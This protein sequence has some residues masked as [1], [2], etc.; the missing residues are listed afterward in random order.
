MVN[1]FNVIDVTLEEVKKSAIEDRKQLAEYEVTPSDEYK[2]DKPRR[3]SPKNCFMKAFRY[4]ADKSHL[5]GVR[6]VHGLYKPA[7]FD[8]HSCHAWVELPND[9]VFDGVMQRFYEKEGY[10]TYYQIIKQKEYDCKIMHKIGLEQGGHFGPW[11]DPY[12]GWKK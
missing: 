10:C 6:L 12:I 5:E 11:H 7:F 8:E 3:L 4:V 2:T 9:I 1:L